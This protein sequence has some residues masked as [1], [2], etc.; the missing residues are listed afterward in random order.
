MVF[1]RLRLKENTIKKNQ[2]VIQM[3]MKG[4]REEE[5]DEE[6]EIDE[7]YSIATPKYR[8]VYDNAYRKV[9]VKTRPRDFY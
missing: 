7:D 4:F 3:H 1:S 6:P 2:D 5:D 8:E 9:F